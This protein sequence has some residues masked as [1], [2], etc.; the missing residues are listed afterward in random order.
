MDGINRSAELL[1]ARA[2]GF[3]K[4][5]WCRSALTTTCIANAGGFIVNFP[6]R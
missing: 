2:K 3:R 5:V 6:R 1:V 4:V